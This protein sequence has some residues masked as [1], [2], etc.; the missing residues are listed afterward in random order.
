MNNE[1]FPN[2]HKIGSDRGGHSSDCHIRVVDTILYLDDHGQQLPEIA[3]ETD[4]VATV[5]RTL[6][7]QRYPLTSEQVDSGSHS[8]RI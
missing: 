6:I 4:L 5:L 2:R 3:E 1:G 8:H 7:T